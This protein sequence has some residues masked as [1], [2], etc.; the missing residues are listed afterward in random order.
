MA[1]YTA[2]ENETWIQISVPCL[3]GLISDTDLDR[4]VRH[5]ATDTE[6][7][8]ESWRKEDL[9]RLAVDIDTWMEAFKDMCHE[10]RAAGEGFFFLVH[11]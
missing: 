4:W 9:P 5:I 11:T 8:K 2:Q 3:L 10:A 6:L 1:T 7:Q